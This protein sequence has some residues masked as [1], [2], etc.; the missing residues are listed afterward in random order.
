MGRI[1]R[2]RIGSAPSVGPGPG[3]ETMRTDGVSGPIDRT[4]ADRS[5]IG[6][7][8]PG[9]KTGSQAQSFLGILATLATVRCATRCAISLESPR[10]IP[11]RPNEVGYSIPRSVRLGRKRGRGGHRTL[12]AG[13]LSWRFP[14]GFIRPARLAR[15]VSQARALDAVGGWLAPFAWSCRSMYRHGLCCAYERHHKS[16]NRSL[17]ALRPAFPSLGRT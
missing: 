4:V 17:S 5:P 10:T 9:K 16:I 7:R 3:H 8:G 15:D 6:V 1:R 14:R 11:S 13:W 2:R 12:A